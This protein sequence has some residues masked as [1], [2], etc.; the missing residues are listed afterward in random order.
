MLDKM[1]YYWTLVAS[2]GISGACG[3]WR[4]DCLK[5]LPTPPAATTIDAKTSVRKSFVILRDATHF[6]SAYIG[7]VGFPSCQAI[8]FQVIV[9][10][11]E[12]DLVFKAATLAG[13]LYG[14]CG[15]YFT[16]R[17]FF[18]RAVNDYAKR[19]DSIQTEF[20]DVL[21]SMPVSDIIERPGA[22]SPADLAEW[23]L[24][25]PLAEYAPVDIVSGGWCREFRTEFK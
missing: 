2:L 10:S 15:V 19:D 21:S 16:D 1:A 8:A 7:L 18:D 3:S 9:E 5:N 20:G 13:Q 12:A 6:Q 14:L 4:A 11:P 25:N 22:I 17:E 23:H 24:E